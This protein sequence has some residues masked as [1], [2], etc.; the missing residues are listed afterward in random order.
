MDVSNLNKVVQVL[1]GKHDDGIRNKERKK[2]IKGTVVLMKKNV[3]DFNDFSAS[4]LDRVDEFLGRK[5]SLQLISSVNG[6]P[7]RGGKGKLGNPAYLENWITTITSLTAGESAFDVTF[8]WDDEE[9][10]VP[11]AFLIRNFHRNEF[12]LRT[13]T[14]E[15]VPDQEK[16]HFVCNSWI[17]PAEKYQSDRIF[18]ANQVLNPNFSKFF[19]EKGIMM[20]STLHT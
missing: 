11:G 5:V 18:F 8:D 3:L 9:M 2:K 4:V 6:D 12:Y 1:T 10:G 15:G 7:E 20:N 19:F 16:I 17:Y 14:L 13:L